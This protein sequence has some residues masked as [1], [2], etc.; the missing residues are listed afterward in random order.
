MCVCVLDVINRSGVLQ[1]YQPYYPVIRAVAIPIR[2]T[3][4]WSA[5]QDKIRGRAST[6]LQQK[7]HKNKNKVKKERK[8]GKEAKKNTYQ[9]YRINYILS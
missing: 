8:K 2:Y 4:T 7:Q 1:H 5:G 6:K 9:K 3:T